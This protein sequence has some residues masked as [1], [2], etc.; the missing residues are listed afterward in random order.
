MIQNHHL[1]SNWQRL[2]LN[3][4]IAPEKG[5]LVSGPFGS[6]IGKKFFVDTGIPVIRGNNLTLGTKKFFD[7]GFVYITESK[8]HEL[9]NC[10]AKCD[11][12]IFTAAGTLGQVGIIPF[13]TIHFYK[14]C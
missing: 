2:H 5:A 6:N 3:E 7:E 14:S 4:I 8:A 11:D 10:E 9:R 1:P 12:I 13:T